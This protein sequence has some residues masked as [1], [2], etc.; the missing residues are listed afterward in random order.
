MDAAESRPD[1][2]TVVRNPMR[3]PMQVDVAYHVAFEPAACRLLGIQLTMQQ[4]IGMTSRRTRERLIQR[5]EET[6]IRNPEVLAVM[7]RLPP[8]VCG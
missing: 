1:N 5:L 8:S 2:L 3:I 7:R 6:G 4:G